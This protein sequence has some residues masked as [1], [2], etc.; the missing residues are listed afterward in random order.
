MEDEL[1]SVKVTTRTGQTAAFTASTVERVR[2]A[3]HFISY[4]ERRGFKKLIVVQDEAVATISIEAPEPFFESI[5]FVDPA[6]TVLHEV[7][8]VL[9]YPGGDPSTSVVNPLLK[10]VREDNI[11]AKPLRDSTGAPASAVKLDG[12]EVVVGAAMLGGVPK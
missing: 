2:G 11:R 4:P 10:M 6:G 7:P 8:P 5:K 12:K 9:G 1:V 3:Y